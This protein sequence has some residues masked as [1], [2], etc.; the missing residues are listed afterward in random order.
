MAPKVS[1][2][3][4]NYNHM[5]YLKQRI[6][7]IL[8]QTYRDF[9]VILLDDASV[10]GSV[11]ILEHYRYNLKVKH[12]VLNTQ[13]SGSTFAQWEKG[14]QLAQGDWVWIAESDDYADPL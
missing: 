2:I 7:S 8:A 13:N 9:E 4:P 14:L 6:D 12:I 11:K 10:D 5:L 3:V 1:V